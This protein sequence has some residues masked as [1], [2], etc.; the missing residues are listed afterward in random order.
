MRIRIEQSL[1]LIVD[2]QAGLLPVIDGGE[3]AVE[4]AI[5]LGGL[6][7]QLEVPVWLTEQYPEGLGA[8]DERL[9]QALPDALRWRKSHF[10]AYDEP[11]FA[12]ALA[13]SGRRQIVICGSEAHICVMQTALGLLDAGYEVYWLAEATASRRHA[14]AQLAMTRVSGAGGVAVSADMVAYEWL[15]RCDDLRFKNVHRQFLKP[16]SARVLRF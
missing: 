14:E 5:W 6:A 13:A 10:G 3:Q 2:L 1:M 8:S 9:L 15:H 11:D 7:S 12:S 4:E 16:R